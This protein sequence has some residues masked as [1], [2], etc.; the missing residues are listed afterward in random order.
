MD[1]SISE[2]L[3]NLYQQYH[4]LEFIEDD[5]ISIPHQFMGKEDI[6][7]SG[8]W[9]A[10]LAW[11]VRKSILKSANEAMKRMDFAP[12]QFILN[13]SE[14]EIRN[15]DNYVHRT[16]NG[17]DAKFYIK[18]LRNIYINEGGLES[19]FSSTLNSSDLNIANGL[20]NAYQ[21]FFSIQHPARTLKHFGNIQKNSAAKRINMF[22]RWMVR[23]DDLG[24]DFG[25]WNKIKPCQLLCP[26]DLH[27]GNI[28]RQLGLLT[29]NMND[30][31]ATLELS[32]NL[33]T[34]DP[35]DP[36]RFDF[37]LFGAGVNKHE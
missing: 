8:F 20:S 22:L 6:E 23:K 18:S 4:T 30:Y 9:T 16:F 5:P 25:L 34:I 26:L 15:F 10:T 37:A 7:I 11:G 24:I 28:A 13:A 31:K 27:S 12:Y 19:I 36:I 21:V 1:M 14:I 17:E 33:S 29:R 35:I 2:I 3:E 32:Q